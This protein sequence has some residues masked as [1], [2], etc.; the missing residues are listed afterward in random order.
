MLIVEHDGS[1]AGMGESAREDE[2]GLSGGGEVMPT[3]EG[4]R[5]QG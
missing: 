3:A 2:A 5:C 1:G 4:S